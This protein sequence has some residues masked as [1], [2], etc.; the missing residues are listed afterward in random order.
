MYGCLAPL[1]I[2]KYIHVCTQQFRLSGS[3]CRPCHQQG[4]GTC[5]A[6]YSRYQHV[7]ITAL[8]IQQSPARDL[9]PSPAR[10]RERQR[11]SE[12]RLELRLP[13]SPPRPWYSAHFSALPIPAGAA[14]STIAAN[15][16][17]S[18]VTN[19]SEHG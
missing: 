8:M 18:A 16:K 6:L 11:E 1:N 17:Q 4:I 13:A 2:D 19:F 3:F 7:G 14:S 10:E 5:R 9:M 12:S 15:L